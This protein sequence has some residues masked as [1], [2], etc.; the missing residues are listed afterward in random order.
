MPFRANEEELKGYNRLMSRFIGPEIA[1]EKRRASKDV[2]G[3]IIDRYGPV[4]EAYPIWH[5]LV[6]AKDSGSSAITPSEQCG[7]EGLDHTFYLRNAFITCPYAGVDRLLKSVEKVSR[8]PF[9]A[10]IAEISAERIDAQLYHPNAQPILV[11][12]DWERRMDRDG[13]IPAGV[14][15]ALILEQQVPCW[16]TAQVGETWKTMCPYLLGQPYGS[17]SSLF[18]NQDTGQ[19]IKDIWNAIINT[20]M[21]GNL[22]VGTG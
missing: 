22:R 21:F 6:A 9:I 15:V 10:G 7:Y 2:L 14:A 12:C 5:P 1:P 3:G 16:R 11:K 18:V 13:T 4:V 19:Q 20:G 8:N 17:R